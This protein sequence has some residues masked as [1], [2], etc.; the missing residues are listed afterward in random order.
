MIRLARVLSPAA[1]LL[2]VTAVHRLAVAQEG[3]P[4]APSL[5]RAPAPWL[6][7]VIMFVLLALVLGVSLLPAKRGH[8]D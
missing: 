8:R 7:Y 5:T 4:P 2:A 6:G 1:M 3:A